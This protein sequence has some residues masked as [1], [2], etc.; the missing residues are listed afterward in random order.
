MLP[1]RVS[2]VD[3]VELNILDF[4]IILVWIDCMHVLR[5]LIV[6]QEWRGLTSLMNPLLSGKGEILFLEVVLSLV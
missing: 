6:G 2:Y 1:N 4:D 3:R 5:P